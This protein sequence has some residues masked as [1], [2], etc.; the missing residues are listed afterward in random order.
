MAFII[1]AEIIYNVLIS[2]NALYKFSIYTGVDVAPVP[3]R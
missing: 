2:T 3:A 1:T